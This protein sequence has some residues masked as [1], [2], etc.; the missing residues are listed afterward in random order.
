MDELKT[1]LEQQG[2]AF[3]AFKAANDTRLAELE[4]KGS[5]DAVT[6]AAVE[7]VN[8]ELTRLD[9]AIKAEAK[10]LNEIELRANRPDLGD[11]RAAEEAKGLD[12][13][14]T[15]LTAHR[16]S[17]GQAAPVISADDLKAYKAGFGRLLRAGMLPN[18]LNADEHKAMSVGSDPD[19]GYLVPPDMTGRIVKKIYDTSPIR[20]LATVQ[21]ISSAS[22]E[23]IVDRDQAGAG[24][25][26]ETGSRTATTSPQVGKYS[27]PVHEMYAN[28]QLTQSVLD[29]AAINLEQWIG[30]KVADRLTRLENTAFVAGTGVGQPRGFTAYSTAATADASRSWGVIEHV[31]SG[32]SADITDSDKLIDLIH[33]LRAPYRVGSVWGMGRLTLAKVRKLKQSNEY[34]WTPVMERNAALTS[35]VLMSGS[36]LGFPV[37]EMDDMPALA[38][39]SLS[40]AFGNFAE[41]Y[42]IVDR[43]GLR[44]LRD[45]YTNKPY[46]GF[47]TTKRVGGDVVNF[48][49]IKLMK[50]NS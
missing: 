38:A 27:I 50:F 37:V 24:W 6:V 25:V 42:T 1:L 47:Y 36:L 12:Q 16:A 21:T 9:S 30:D 11:P 15:T 29:D 39:D 22:L 19:G 31:L 48:E 28:P 13:W 40:I 4:K 45:P 32:A 7:K 17:K 43:I 23:G 46:V 33:A 3:E 49:A 14:Q 20:Q 41:A 5:A 35:A 10:R 2:K 18:H 34:I 26:A 44:V 8:T